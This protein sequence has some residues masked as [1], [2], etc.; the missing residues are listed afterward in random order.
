MGKYVDGFVIPVPKKNLVAYKKFARYASQL[1]I[2]CG[3]L[4]Y[5]ESIGDDVPKGKITS[6]PKSVNLKGNETIIFAYVVYKSRTH[7]NQVMKKVMNDEKMTK[8][9]DSMPFDGM[10]MIWGGFKT[11]I[12][13]S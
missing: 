1:W 12:R 2:K 9:W 5:V 4:E 11:I 7:R 10:R 8:M 6:F 3:A 13:N